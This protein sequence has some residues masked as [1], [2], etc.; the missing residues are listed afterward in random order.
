MSRKYCLIPMLVAAFG[1]ATLSSSSIAQEKPSV[2]SG[3][4]GNTSQL[5]FNANEQSLSGTFTVIDPSGAT[6]SVVVQDGTLFL[7]LSLDTFL[8]EPVPLNEVISELGQVGAEVDV[9]FNP[10]SPRDAA[11]NFV[12]TEVDIFPPAPDPGEGPPPV[13]FVHG[14]VLEDQ[15]AFS[16]GV[17]TGSFTVQVRDDSGEVLQDPSGNP[18]VEAIVV[19]SDTKFLLLIP[20]SPEPSP[21]GG[22]EVPSV[23]EPQVSVDVSGQRDPNTQVL[24]AD[25][26]FILPGLADGPGGGP[27]FT[28]DLLVMGIVVG[29][30]Q[31]TFTVLDIDGK[32]T[33]VNVGP[34]VVYQRVDFDPTDPEAPPT[35]S[36]ASVQDVVQN[37]GVQVF[38]EGGSVTEV[39][40]SPGPGGGP[41]D[42]PISAGDL[43]VTGFVVAVGD[44]SF[45]VRDMDGNDTVVNVGPLVVYQ[46]ISFDPSDPEAPPMFEDASI[47]DVVQNVGV[48]VFAEGGNVTQVLISQGP[49]DGDGPQDPSGLEGDLLVSGVIVVVGQGTFT[50]REPDGKETVVTVGSSVVY[51][52]ISFDPSDPEAPP[53]FEDAS[54]QDVVQNVGVDVFEQGGNVTGVLILPGPADGGGPQG[55]PVVQ[56]LV[57]GDVQIDFSQSPLSGTFMVEA[58]DELGN[59]INDAS[60]NPVIETIVVGA[61][62]EFLD[63]MDLD[64]TDPDQPPGPADPIDLTQ[65]NIEVGVFGQRDPNTQQIVA[66]QVFIQPGPGDG[67]EPP[68]PPLVEGL[69]VGDVQID[70]SQS[71]LSGTFMV[72]ARDELGNVINDASG[73]PVIE[74]I[75]VGASTQFLD[76]TDLDPTD[77]NQPPGPAD[78]NDLTQPN[79][80]VGVFG[81]RDPNTNE[82][83]ADQ[84][85]I[86]PGPGDGG[87]PQGPPLVEGLVVGDVQIDFSQSPLS[88]T[89]MVEARDEFGNVIND[90]S[91][92]PVVETVVVEASTEFLDPT[93]PNQPPGPADPKDLTQPNIGVGVFG[94]RDPNT[95]EI[96][97]DQ[98]FIQSAD[99]GGPPGPPVVEGL[100]VG[101]VQIDFSQ[102]SLS[103]TFMVEARDEFGN[104]INDASGN[105]VV[106]TVVVEASTEF[107]DPT[108]PNQPVPA[109]PKDLAQPN[110]EV[111]VFGQRDPSTMQIVAEQV[112]IQP[113]SADGGGPPGPPVVE[114]LVVGDVQIDFSQSPLS[115]TFMVEARDEFGNVIND[116]SGNPVVET[117]VVEASTEFLDPTDPNQPPVPA[118]PKDLANP[119]IGVGVFGQRDPNTNEII[120]DQVF[121]LPVDGPSPGDTEPPPEQIVAIPADGGMIDKSTLPSLDNLGLENLFVDIPSGALS[122]PVDVRIDVP[123]PADFPPDQAALALKAVRFTIEGHPGRFDFDKPVT[124]GIPY[125]DGINE[126]ALSMGEWNPIDKVWMPLFPDELLETIIV[127]TRL[128]VVSSQVT[129]FSIYG[130]LPVAADFTASPVSDRIPLT[131]RFTDISTGPV[132]DWSWDFGDQTTTPEQNEQNPTHT[133]TTVGKFSVTLLVTAPPGG[134]SKTIPDLIEVLKNDPPDMPVFV[135]PA[136]GATGVSLNPTLEWNPSSDPEGDPIVYDVFVNSDRFAS[137]D[138]N[139]G[140]TLVVGPLSENTTYMW[141]VVARDDRGGEAI[142]TTSSFTT[143]GDTQAPVVIRDPTVEDITEN[144]ATV[145]WAVDEE[146][147]PHVE[148]RESGENTFT[149]SSPGSAGTGQKV[150]LTGLTSG[151]TYEFRVI[152]ED[153]SPNKNQATFPETSDPP[154]T[155]MTLAVKDNT[156]P[157]FTVPV[158]AIHVGETSVVVFWETDERSTT[159][160][161][162]RLETETTFTSAPAGDAGT[163]HRLEIPGLTSGSTYI[164]RVRSED[165]SLNEAVGSDLEVTTALKAILIRVSKVSV[166]GRDTAQAIIAWSTNV[167]GS[168][169]VEYGLES[170][171][172]VSQKQTGPDGVLEH[173]VTLTKL[174]QGTKYFYRAISGGSGADTSDVFSFRTRKA[175]PPKPVITEGPVVKGIGQDRATVLWRTNVVGNSTVTFSTDP[176]LPAS[177]SGEVIDKSE[178]RFRLGHSVILTGLSENT[179][180]Y[181]TVKSENIARVET[182]SQVGDFSTLKTKDIIK[183]SFLS[184]PAVTVRTADGF[185]VA[186]STNELATSELLFGLVGTDFQSKTEPGFRLD[187]SVSVSGLTEET[188]YSYKVR[189]EDQAM[190]KQESSDL[191]VKT[192]PGQQLD[193]SSPELVGSPSETGTSDDGTTIVWVTDEPSNSLVDYSTTAGDL[194]ESTGDPLTFTTAHSVPLTG[195]TATTLYHYRI[196]SV[197]AAGNP[198]VFPAPP[199]TQTF[200]TKDKPDLTSPNISALEVVKGSVTD[201]SATLFWKSDEPSDSQIEYAPVPVSDPSQLTERFESSRLTTGHK[202]TLTDLSPLTT[203]AFRVGAQDQARNPRTYK[204]D[205]APYPTFKT[206]DVPDTKSA[207]FINGTPFV[208]DPTANTLKVPVDTDEPT[209]LVVEYGTTDYS[210][211]RI[212]Q[213]DFLTSR[214]VTLTGLKPQTQYIVR[215]SCRDR[216][217]NPTATADATTNPQL[218]RSTTKLKD[219]AE[220]VFLERP[221]VSLSGVNV[222]VRWVTDEL[223]DSKVIYGTLEDFG[224]A[225]REDQAFDGTLRTVHLVSL[226]GLNLNTSYRFRVESKDAAGN[227]GKSGA[228][229]TK[230]V[231]GLA[232][233][234]PGGE[235][236]FCDP[237]YPGH[238]P[239]GYPVGADVGGF[240]VYVAD[241]RLGNGR[242]LGQLF[243]IWGRRDRQP[244]RGRGAG[245]ETPDGFDQAFFRDHLPV[246][247]GVHGPVAQRPC[248]EQAGGGFHIGG[249]G[250]DTTEDCGRCRSFI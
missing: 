241:D 26:V 189:S 238:E 247:G 68:G 160:A 128:K 124:I 18:V 202:V 164:I 205:T 188:D 222:V 19:G 132:T 31:G 167:P 219:T 235:G 35:F 213:G 94:Q 102:S 73:N 152:S 33:V 67:G 136:D 228:L 126:D 179:K 178:P 79:I 27:I 88:G 77:P 54:I 173:R 85:F 197:D 84:V 92:N 78:P 125:P 64:P 198:T 110:I 187:H 39:W 185:T 230:P 17:L 114:G 153:V 231:A 215:V 40:I 220:P 162:Y 69:V 161:S 210:L 121:I 214:I 203:Y 135:S 127:D 25:E 133:Y 42:G 1:L 190:N 154:L 157:E 111:G 123:D 120:A 83:V 60:G 65:P 80:E 159:E 206:L 21:V 86:Q 192:L 236:S 72:E 191:T 43:L 97:A 115:G 13:E 129:H 104:V 11:G 38:A 2:I 149:V 227:T 147:I 217:G 62:T 196:T 166:V 57:V 32:E 172:R 113:G 58:R 176:T 158:S 112:F 51:Q 175:P 143:V 150:P 183:P 28:G 144:T 181:Y 182:V 249:G 108:D 225:D 47:Q 243:G 250:R 170:N 10:N 226:G 148:Y 3:F 221:T 56:G 171:L 74:T 12:A 49:G 106:E 245:Y 71:P 248:A 75:V 201:G 16:N 20:G 82:I 239:T 117:I 96:I 193:L 140:T 211:G 204:P 101:D 138:V 130:V 63:P 6:R 155:F 118:D 22:Q 216:A 146:S 48:E 44:G 55:D 34:L 218:Q 194:L 131:V 99:E 90:A 139:E 30:G 5:N 76:P 81:Q 93:D 122:A 242:G 52:R 145:F 50:V 180:Y 109:D 119:N 95:N 209:D 61:A 223:S 59:V 37:V 234:P 4:V 207:F 199:N 116:A 29:L 7:R 237:A 14:D 134:A 41:G 186:W 45:T 233:Q 195:L 240:H 15:V 177:T 24:V 105:P 212:E 9:L 87:G 224:A 103:G 66:D 23:L 208:K 229:L 141:H 151:T 232:L 8:F 174:Q 163:E 169:E 91:G 246:C 137:L 46:R 89:F 36:P 184:G 156:E 168:S 53:M 165:A 142:G 107:L 200:T 100:V 98:V 70:F 244:D